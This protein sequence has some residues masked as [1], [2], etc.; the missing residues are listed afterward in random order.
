[1]KRFQKNPIV[2]FLMNVVAII[3]AY[4]VSILLHE[5]A[6]G[7]AA[8]LC[9]AKNSPFNVQY[10]GWFLMN[11]DE[12]VNYTQLI[13]SG[14]G[15]SAALIGIAGSSVS[16]IFA[17]ICFILL[18]N[19][20]FRQSAV[21]FI[22][23]YWFL[24]INMVPLVQYLTISTFSSRGDVGRFIYGLNIS[25]WWVFFPGTLFIIFSVIRI[26]KIEVPKSYAVIPIKSLLG[27]NIFLLA[28]LGILFLFIYTHGYNPLTDQG[29]NTFSRALA[30]LSIILVPILFILCY[31]SRNW[32][33]KAVTRY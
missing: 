15:L 5:W 8:W 12:N 27:Q 1:M 18:S 3:V 7:I 9:G 29:M 17:V 19:K 25:A 26:L 31:P 28:T 6:H 13:D 20:N 14:R 32:V 4:Y 2:I 21:K 30:I 23:V 24:M 22:F 16:F 10:G 33:K 11:A